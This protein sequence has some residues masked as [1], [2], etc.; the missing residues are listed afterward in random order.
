MSISRYSICADQIRVFATLAVVM[1]HV[2]AN[3]LNSSPFGSDSWWLANFF[4]AASRSSIPLFVMLSG[5]L[6]LSA[7]IG[8][9]RQFYQRR[10]SRVLLPLVVWSIFYS[11]WTMLKAQVKGQPIMTE[12]VWLNLVSGT[13]YFHL[14]YLFML[15]GLYAIAPVL[16]LALHSA[17]QRF[18]PSSSWYL[19]LAVITSAIYTLGYSTFVDD[20]PWPFWFIGYIPLMVLGAVLWGKQSSVGVVGL[21]CC[22]LVMALIIARLCYIQLAH[23]PEVAGIYSYQYLSLPVLGASIA[24]WYLLSRPYRISAGWCKFIAPYCFGIYLL[25]PAFLDLSQML[26]RPL[27]LPTAIT[28]LVQFLFVFALSLASCIG[29]SKLRRRVPMSLKRGRE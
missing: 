24:C 22:Y 12:Q 6:L 8:D 2:S 1:L 28:M 3:G 18:N 9:P 16:S 4:D 29:Y 23:Y 21:L 5:A 26:F 20:W 25:H 7:P 19:L 10:F 15:A 27:A 14:W 13:P 17:Q 11:G